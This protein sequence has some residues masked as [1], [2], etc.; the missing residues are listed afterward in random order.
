MKS[1][2]PIDKQRLQCCHGVRIAV[3]FEFKNNYPGVLS[4]MC[5]NPFGPT[6]APMPAEA[7]N[8]AILLIPSFFGANQKQNMI[9]GI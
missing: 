5:I 9:M 2:Y 7:K 3:E 8:V 6:P 1:Q 4:D